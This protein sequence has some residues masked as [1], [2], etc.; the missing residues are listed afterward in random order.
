[1]LVPDWVL[2][3]QPLLG[4]TW[5]VGRSWV[6]LAAVSTGT[7]NLLLA[8][9]ALLVLPL[10][11]RQQW[12]HLDGSSQVLLIPPPV[13]EVYRRWDKWGRKQRSSWVQVLT[14]R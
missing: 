4:V 10:V 13:L 2:L 14:N 5:A 7:H 12:T 3:V 11:R 6:V 1:L 9:L 8:P